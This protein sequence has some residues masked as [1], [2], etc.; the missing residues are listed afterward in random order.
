MLLQ[1]RIADAPDGQVVGRAV[2]VR[3]GSGGGGQRG[4]ALGRIEGTLNVQ[5]PIP[6]VEGL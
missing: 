5:R 3:E 6:N 1:D 4:E 2:G